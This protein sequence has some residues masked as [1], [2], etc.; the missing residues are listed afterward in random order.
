MKECSA[1]L[2]TFHFK[3]NGSV[4]N[5]SANTGFPF[6]GQVLAQAAWGGGGVTVPGG[7]QE[8]WRCGTERHG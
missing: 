2:F 6:L 7:V 3:P 8:L 4:F 1:A 5:T